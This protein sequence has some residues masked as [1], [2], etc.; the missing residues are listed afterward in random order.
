[1]EV[2]FETMKEGN[3]GIKQSNFTNMPKRLQ[4]IFS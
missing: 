3:T 4:Y 1:M 2:F